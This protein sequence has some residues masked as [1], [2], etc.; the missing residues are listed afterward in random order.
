MELLLSLRIAL[1]ALRVNKLRSSLTMLGIIIGIAAVIVMVA[2]GSAANQLLAEQIASL[3]SNIIRVNPGSTVSGGLRAGAGTIPSLT[4]DDVNAIRAECP[5]V[6]LVAPMVRRSAQVVGGNMNWST[7]IEGITPELLMI[8]DW[9]VV[10]GRGL[11]QSD[12]DGTK[13]L[14]LMGQTVAEM[15]FGDEDPVGHVIRVNRVP[16]T[17]VGL[18]ERKGQSPG[19]ADQDDVIF[20]P[21]TTV[22]R[23]IIGSSFPNSVGAI[24]VQA[25]SQEVLAQAEEEVTALLDQ[26]HRVGP[27]KDRDF[28][29]RNVSEALAVSK[30]SAETMATLLGTVAIISLIVGGIGIMNIM[31]VSVS[32][33]TREIG[34]RMAI[35]AKQRDILSQFLTEA[36]LLTLLGGLVGIL[37]GIVLAAGVSRFLQWPTL[38]SSQAIALAFLF[39]AGVGVFFGFYPATK[40][41]RL[42]PIEALRYE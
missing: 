29:I 25:K 1:R 30:Q 38:I 26:R 9:T 20:I 16:V 15:L 39:S 17:V 23:K 19:G 13:K 21:I 37:L 18:M 2:I 32:E 5:S 27:T 4:F 24:V 42:D 22:I 35:G 8:R 40:A 28:F 34:I 3:G 12:V 33:R 7:M 6:A 36:V 10:S 14:C 31:L 11:S 41:A